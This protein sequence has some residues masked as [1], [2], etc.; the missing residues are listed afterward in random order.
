MSAL[1]DLFTS[2]ANKIR[3]KLGTTTTYT[4]AQAIAAIDNVYT[5]GV[6]D[7]K[8][9]NATDSD[10][11]SGKTYTST[12]G[13]NRTGTFA[14]Q[15]LTITPSTGS[16]SIYPD[17]GKYFNEITVDSIMP[18]IRTGTAAS[19]AGRD[20][21]G[22]YVSFPY[23]WWPNTG[24]N[25]NYTRLTNAQAISTVA[26]EEQSGGISPN[27]TTALVV[28]P[29]SG[30]LLSK[31]S[32]SVTAHTATKTPTG[33]DLNNS[34]M[35][36]GER[37]NYRYINTAVCYSNGKNT[38][39]NGLQITAFAKNQ[40]SGT[41][42]EKPPWAAD[43]LIVLSTAVSVDATNK[44]KQ[45]YDNYGGMKA[46]FYVCNAAPTITFSGNGYYTIYLVQTA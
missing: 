39:Y 13:V 12:N 1:T 7:T 28:T 43:Y 41:A 21:T 34:A 38:C 35:N 17:D 18:Q 30:K 25:T 31:V 6:T 24:S 42:T 3:S 29:S 10:V 45:S 5:K 20:S 19:A 26:T 33:S 23:G 2:L 22:P 4:P 8:K 36:L 27:S 14:A 15:P 44:V 32:V 46:V 11:K 16:Q 9:G 37:H 40:V